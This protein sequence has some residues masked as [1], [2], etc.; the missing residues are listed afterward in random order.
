[1]PAVEFSGRSLSDLA[2]STLYEI[3]S[4]EPVGVSRV[5]VIRSTVLSGHRKLPLMSFEPLPAMVSLVVT[6]ASVRGTL[7]FVGAIRG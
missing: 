7:H 5:T 1:M 3:V 4:F 6:S 2:L